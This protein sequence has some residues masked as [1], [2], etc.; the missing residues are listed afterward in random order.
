VAPDTAEYTTTKFSNVEVEVQ[1]DTTLDE[2][3]KILAEDCKNRY[4]LELHFYRGEVNYDGQTIN[5]YGFI[6]GNNVY[7]R[8]DGTL[9]GQEINT[10]IE[11]EATHRRIA[12]EPE[13]YKDAR[14]ALRKAMD[15][16]EYHKWYSKYEQMYGEIYKGDEELI[17]E[18]MMV[19][20][21]VGAIKPNYLPSQ[22]AIVKPW[23]NGFKKTSTKLMKQKIETGVKFSAKDKTPKKNL[24][25]KDIAQLASTDYRSGKKDFSKAKGYEGREYEVASVID[26]ENKNGELLRRKIKTIE[27]LKTVLNAIKEGKI[28]SP[29]SGFV[30]NL[31][32]ST[33]L[34]F[35]FKG[36]RY[37]AAK[38]IFDEI[39]G[40]RQTYQAEEF[41]SRSEL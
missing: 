33:V 32:Q 25:E 26:Y 31:I 28:G 41:A 37:A 15:T 24:T 40:P 5:A 9:N 30:M 11:H 3:Q 19:D 27:D 36:K 22:Q 18:E 21:F 20:I 39:Q 2:H 12:A 35:N 34:T 14:A 29:E 38:A 1:N 4:G 8:Y 23:I 10:V 13:K 6:D 16:S 7:L 17:E